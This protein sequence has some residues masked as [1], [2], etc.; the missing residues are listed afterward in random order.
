MSSPNPIGRLGVVYGLAAYATW[1][2]LPLYIRLLDRAPAGQIVA[3]RAVWALVFL[4]GIVAVLGRFR[5]IL[6]R[7]RGKHV[8]F[9]LLAST[10]LISINWLVYTWGVVNHH[11]LETSLGYFINPLVNVALGMIFLGERLSRAQIVAV[12]LA[13]AGVSIMAVAQGGAL[14]ISLTLAFSFGLYGL[15]R[16]VVAIDALGGLLVE[17]LL[18]APVALAYLIWMDRIGQGAFGQDRTLDLLLVCGGLLTVIPL[19]LFAAAA[20]RL[21]YSTLGLIQYVAP[22][23]QF[24]LAVFVFREALSAVHLVTF[25]LIWLGLVIYAL[26][27]WRATRAQ[28]PLPP[29]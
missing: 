12:G 11:V 8:L 13:A 7:A 21:P 3:H 24:L 25:A 27:S 18:L 9:A 14:W 4:G 1:G 23:M 22:T 17:T 28:S 29:E 10:T 15:I 26:D 6:A 20:R 5:A 16:K 19:L 2:L